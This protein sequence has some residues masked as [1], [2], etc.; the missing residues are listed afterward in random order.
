M[1]T[2]FKNAVPVWMK[3]REKKM[4]Q[5]VQFKTVFDFSANQAV[6]LNLATSGIYHLYVN[7]TFVA[8]GPARAGKGHF[9]VDQ[10][11]LTKYVTAGKNTVVIEVAGYYVNSFYL[12]KAPSF[13]TAELSVDGTPIQWTGEHFTARINPFYIEKVQRYSYQRP[14]MEAYCMRNSD[15]YLTDFLPGAEHPVPVCGGV[16]LPRC[17]PYPQFE[18]ICA[19]PI[20]KAGTVALIEPETYLRDRSITNINKELCGFPFEELTL[21]VTDACQ[22]MQFTPAD[23]FET[24]KLAANTY[25]IYKYPFNATGMVTLTVHC[26]APVT[27]YALFDEVLLGQTVDYMRLECANIFRFELPAGRHSLTCF[28]VYTMQYLQLVAVGGS[29]TV[30]KLGMIEYKHPPV[31]KTI[32]TTDPTIAKI[33]DA[34]IESYR[35]NS[36]DG[37]TDCPSR[38][39]AGWLCDSFFTSKVEFLLTGK[40]TIETAF[41]ENFLHED[42]FEGLP[43][44]M[45]PMCYPSDV[46]DGLHIPNWAMFM[47]MELQARLARTGDNAF[48]QRFREKVFRLL[49]YFQQ[50]ENEDGLLESL[51]NWVFVE[52][53]KA[54]ELTLDVNYPSNMLY[55][56]VL[57]A[58]GQMYDAPE[59]LEKAE[60][61]KDVILRQSFNGKFF[62]DNALRRDGKLVFPNECT[63]VCQYYA[64]FFGI[65]TKETHRDLLETLIRDFGPDRDLATCHPEIYP[66]NAFIGNYLRLDIL[67][68][69][70]YYSTL[71]ENIKGYFGYMAERTGTLWEHVGSTASCNHGFASYVLCIL[72]A[73]KAKGLF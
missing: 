31:A 16:Y 52:W 40:N 35:Q 30:E 7:G 37:F 32:E 20:G 72:D 6:S 70:G 62:M 61:I 41:L 5:R 9:R 22:R 55:Y 38:E 26:D 13:L 63:E 8:Y 71:L 10:W 53:S 12:L 69:E 60:K 27:L 50:F 24:G 42:S 18:R 25:E 56:A 29:C 46:Y 33:V 51:P 49:D 58:T 11:D 48:I 23:A 14:M 73:L 3:G 66:A 19:E 21:C 68:E 57:R 54:N 64:F 28:E 2:F 65:A 67:L 43:E 15:S 47:V 34:A 59:L 4:H 1:D 45:V 44:G 36:V 17:A 39:R